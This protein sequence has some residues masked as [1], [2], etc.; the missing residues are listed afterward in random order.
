MFEYKIREFWWLEDGE[1]V[2]EWLESEI[3]KMAK[4]GWRLIF[5]DIDNSFY[6]FERPVKSEA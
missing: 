3:N 2:R 5:I 6:H 4:D 1:K